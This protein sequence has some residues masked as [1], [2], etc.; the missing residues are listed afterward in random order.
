MLVNWDGRMSSDSA[1]AALYGCVWQQLITEVFRDQFPEAEWPMSPGTRAENA[2]HYLL[3]DPNAGL[4]DDITTPERETRD[5]ILVRTFRRAYTVLVEKEGK[6]PKKWRWDKLHTITFVNQTLGKSGIGP[7]EKIFN[8][9]PF[10]IAGGISQV[11]AQA[12]ES[13]KPFE[14]NH[15]PSMRSIVD[16]GNIAGAVGVLPTGESGHPGNRHYD[17][18]IKLYLKVQYHPALWDRA[19]VER[20]A[21]HRLVLNPR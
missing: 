5:E 19:D 4:W 17:D 2:I 8:R 1:A 3:Q 14:V 16:M 15:Y 21:R 13:K 9:G 6:N 11:N 18:F 10:P 12:W 20:S 7:I